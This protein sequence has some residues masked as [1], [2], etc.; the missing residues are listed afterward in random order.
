MSNKKQLQ[1]KSVVKLTLTWEE[2]QLMESVLE[3]IGGTGRPR[4][5]VDSVLMQ[6]AEV[7]MSSPG[8]FRPKAVAHIEFEEV[9]R[10]TK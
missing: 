1:A 5:L 7:R 4:V 3:I 2:A 9:K 10:K 6:L 8:R